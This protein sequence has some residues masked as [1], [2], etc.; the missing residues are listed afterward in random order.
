MKP[1]SEAASGPIDRAHYQHLQPNSDSPSRMESLGCIILPPGEHP[2]ATTANYCHFHLQNHPDQDWEN[3][4]HMCAFPNV[5]AEERDVDDFPPLL[6]SVEE[7]DACPLVS[8]AEARKRQIA[9]P[10]RWVWRK[11]GDADFRVPLS[12]GRLVWAAAVEG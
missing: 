1:L 6:A 4:G 9:N 3:L 11:R 5:D 12:D 7:L 10:C 8:L 2:G